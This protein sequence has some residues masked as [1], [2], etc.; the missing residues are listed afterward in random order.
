MIEACERA[1]RRG[2]CGVHAR[3]RAAG[4]QKEG[5]CVCVWGGAGLQESVEA[6]VGVAED[7][8]DDRDEESAGRV[9][10]GHAHG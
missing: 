6:E 7:G 5:M 9:G 1:W 4:G 8:A 10:L 2:G 3:N